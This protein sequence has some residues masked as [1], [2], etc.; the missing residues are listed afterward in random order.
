M[1]VAAILLAMIMT[2][3]VIITIPLVNLLTAT[4]MAF[5]TITV[6]MAAETAQ[7]MLMRMGMVSATTMLMVHHKMVPALGEGVAADKADA[8]LFDSL[9]R[10]FK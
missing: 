4:A 5:V 2:V 7:D 1:L 8:A 9:H 6:L 10:P 3:C